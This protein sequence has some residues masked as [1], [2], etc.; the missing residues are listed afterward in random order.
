MLSPT[1]VILLWTYCRQRIL[2][3]NYTARDDVHRRGKSKSASFCHR[4]HSLLNN[5]TTTGRG[6]LDRKMLC[7]SGHN[8]RIASQTS[9]DR[10]LSTKNDSVG[11]S[12][13][14]LSV[15]YCL[16]TSV[17]SNYL[18]NLLKILHI[19]INIFVVIRWGLTV[20]SRHCTRSIQIL[21]S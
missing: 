7:L 8:R 4:I 16:S 9:R 11:G 15:V 13:T 10:S 6:E 3:E 19:K 2:H 12:E 14:P 18:K 17:I 5:N 20:A 1:F 21:F